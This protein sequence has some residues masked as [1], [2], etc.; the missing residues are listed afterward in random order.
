MNIIQ[1]N[2]YGNVSLTQHT[3]D[4]AILHVDHAKSKASVSLYGGQV[5]SWQPNGQ[6][7]VLWMSTATEYK[8]GKAIRGGI[9]LCWPWFGPF[10]DAGN[11]GFARQSQWQYTDITICAEQVTIVLEFD[12]GQCHDAWPYQFKLT[13]TIVFGEQ[14]SQSLAITNA[15]DKTIE[16]SGALHSYFRVSDPENVTVPNLNRS[17]FDDKITQGNGLTDDLVNC[18]GPIDRIYYTNQHQKIIDSGWQRNIEVVSG[19]CEQWVLWNPGQ[20]IADNMPDIHAGGFNEYVC[21]EAANTQWV[22]VP[23]QHTMVMSQQVK[24]TPIA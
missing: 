10:N 7:E 15:T 9:P 20:A 3:A 1:S 18:V 8:S 21:L 14:F 5:L 11:H 13:Q 6:Q 2:E 19:G 16:C 12:G 4:V 22:S 17:V 23:A 24:V